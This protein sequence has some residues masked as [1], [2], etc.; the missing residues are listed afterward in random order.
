MEKD[1][2]NLVRKIVKLSF[3]YLS[4]PA[5]KNLADLIMAFF[6]NRSFTL[7]EIAS[8][9][10]GE[11]TAKHKHKRLIYF[12][13]HLVLDRA[14]WKSLI[15]TVFSLPGFRFRSRKY[16]TLALDATT[17]KDDFWLLAVSVSYQGRAIPIYL[18]SWAGVNSSY[19]YWRR[20]RQVL[21][22][23]KELLPA[24][25]RF[26]LVADRGFQG[27]EMLKIL[28]QIQWDYVVRV[29]GCYRMKLADGRE[30]VQLD[31]FADGWYEEVTLG[32]RA[33][34]GPLNLAINSVE[35]EEGGLSRWYLMS[36]LPDGEHAL[37]SYQRRFWIE[38]GFKD[39]KSKLRWESYTQKV[40]ASDR[41]TKCIA[42]S[43][44]SYAI[45]TSLGSQICLSQSE[46][47]KTSVFH[48]FR[49]A[50]RRTNEKLQKIITKF[51]SMIYTYLRR[52][53]IA[54]S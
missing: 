30:F 44:L 27:E 45:Q 23:L 48:R 11:T 3:T 52:T 39:L 54:F 5:Q 15:M 26:E 38:E 18:R 28:Q 50:Y 33:G 7:W 6:Y 42:V 49:Q 35:N 29:N 16:L 51:I 2:F 40:P 47:K 17:L 13:D 43:C 37:R 41:L 46:Q 31:M 22:E 4:L 14:F 19:D 20:V 34:M 53:Q 1:T 8:C 25:Y 12:L 9:L 32:K 24:K 21:V 10:S 36:N